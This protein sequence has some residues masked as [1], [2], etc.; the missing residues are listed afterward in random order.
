V[1]KDRVAELK[2]AILAAEANGWQYIG[3]HTVRRMAEH[4]TPQFA[5]DN[6]WAPGAT[7][8]SL[9]FLSF[10]LHGPSRVP[11]CIYGTCKVP[12]LMRHDQ[13]ISWK[14]TLELLAE[15]VSSSDVH[16]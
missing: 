9:E 13:K 14:R 7:Y 15:P 5:V 1:A 4:V 11:T 10:V 3:N 16:N 6:G 2:A 12:W 8:T